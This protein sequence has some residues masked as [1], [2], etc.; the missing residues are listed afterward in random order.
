MRLGVGRSRLAS[1]T[2]TRTVPRAAL[3]LLGAGSGTRSGHRTNKVF[4]SLA[5][6]RVFVWTLDATRGDPDIGPV[7]LVVRADEQDA[8]R[9]VLAREAPGR[10]VRIVVGGAS[11]HA[12]ESRALQA[13]RPDVERGEVDV[14]VVHDAA[15]PLSGPALFRRVVATAREY[16]GAVP[17]RAQPALL[18]RDGMQQRDGDAVAVQT[19][20]AF[21]SRPLLRAYAAADRNGFEGSDTAACVER[22]APDVAIRHVPGSPSNIKITYAEDLFLAEA[23]LARSSYDLHRLGLPDPGRPAG[24]D[25]SGGRETGRALRAGGG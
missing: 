8:A 10:Q 15:R 24:K 2:G 20:Q 9:E 1:V 4:L 7:V 17:G 25:H 16:G 12:S 3:V 21:S 19:P 23:L 18:H 11:R 5:G 22:F 14:V 13:L 6:R